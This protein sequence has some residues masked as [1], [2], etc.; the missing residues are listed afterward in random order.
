MN[1]EV[2]IL[3][4]SYNMPERANAL[5]RYIESHIKWPHETFLID[6]GSDIVAPSQFTGLWLPKNVQTTNG[7]LAGLRYAKSH[8]ID[9][10][11]YWFIITSSEFPEGYNGDPLSPMAQLLLDD[12]NAVGIHPALTQDSTT[13][14][15]HLIDTGTGKPRQ[16]WM[17]DNIA[18]LY[19]ADWLD[20]IGWF[21]EKLYMAHGIDLETCWKARRD[22]R[23]LWV[24]EESHI[25]KVTNIGYAMNRMNMSA[26][27]RNALAQANM[28]DI[29]GKRYGPNYWE[30]LTMEYRDD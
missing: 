9:W 26:N 4:V 12:P 29:L 10:L 11:A 20:G 16:T 21:D 15:T 22:G 8:D 25:K 30:R 3:I 6:N 18:S 2:A 28:N 19:R 24:H 13:M 14:W 23:A 7:W 17:I 27:D 1:N 5:Y